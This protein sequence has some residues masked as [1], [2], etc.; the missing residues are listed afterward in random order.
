MRP[1][2]IREF[3]ETRDAFWCSASRTVKAAR[4]AGVRSIVVFLNKCDLIDDLE[5]LYLIEMEVRELLNTFKYP[6]DD[7][8]VIRGSARQTL[9][10]GHSK[11]AEGVRHLLAAMDATISP[12]L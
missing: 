6:G 8:R 9:E 1:T 4:A 12:P 7:A 5:M 11:W 2:L 3:T 10:D